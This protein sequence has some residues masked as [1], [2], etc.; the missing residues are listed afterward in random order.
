MKKGVYFI[1]GIDTGVGKSFAAGWIA[2][3]WN[4]NGINTVTQKFIQTGNTCFS[5][6]ILIHRKI[7]GAELPDEEIPYVMPEIFSFPASPHLSARIDNRPVDLKKIEASTDWLIQKYDA[8]LIE[9]A[10]GI[11]VPIS[12]N[13]LTIDYIKEKNYPVI[14]V[15]SGKLGSIN[16]TLLTLDAIRI[17]GL[18]LYALVYN[19]YPVENET[20]QNDTELYLKNVITRDWA[21]TQFLV[22]PEIKL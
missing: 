2:R 6:D 17:R 1:S 13:Y 16:H 9:G 21:F 3:E 7:M 10:G 18:S 4:K 12:G 14:L 11:M 19:K 22:M 20:I 8:V 15:T 5:E